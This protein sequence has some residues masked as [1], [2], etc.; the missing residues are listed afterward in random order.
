MS[1]QRPLTR[2]LSNAPPAIC[3]AYAMIVAF[4]TYFC[5]YAFRKPFAAATYAGLHLFGTGIELKTALVISQI[6]GYTVSKFIGIKLCSEASRGRRVPM[7]IGLIVAAELALVLFAVLPNSW[8]VAAIFLNGLPLGMVWGLVVWYLEGRTSSDLLLAGLS[9]SFIVSSGVVK[10]VGRALMVGDSLPFFGLPIPN[11]LPAVPEFWM[12]AATG[13]LFLPIFLVAVWLLDQVPDPTPADIAARTLRQPMDRGRRHAFV[14]RYLPGVAMLLAAYFFLTA[15]RDFR[16]NYIVEILDQLGYKFAEHKDIISRME[17]CVA[18]GVMVI[19]AL[20]FLIRDNRRGLTAIFSVMIA[21][22]VLLAAAT[23]ML[24]AGIIN[25]FWWMM[26]IGLGSYLAYVPYN[27]VLFD[28][29]IASTG[30]VGTAVFAIYLADTLGYSGSVIVQLVKDLA[31]SETSRLDF[32]RD[33]CYFTSLFGAVA[34][35]ASCFYFVRR[36]VAH[37]ANQVPLVV[38]KEFAAEIR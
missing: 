38:P 2:A 11:P 31:S 17:L 5:M 14:M 35:V 20:P 21:G 9:C 12:P 34:F 32:M 13:L 8:K 25:G 27:S 18:F 24:D 30:F 7:L 10:D 22:M 26:L 4:S 37:S 19:V 36:D 33:M 6:I 28:R 15:F 1:T 16:D 3:N 23:A 29:L